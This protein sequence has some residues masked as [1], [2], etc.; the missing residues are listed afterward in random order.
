MKNNTDTTSNISTSITSVEITDKSHLPGEKSKF[1]LNTLKSVRPQKSM[2][3]IKSLKPS[4]SSVLR[5]R[6]VLVKAT[7]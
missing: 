1:D 4:R 2:M 5:T 3:R 6:T 7:K